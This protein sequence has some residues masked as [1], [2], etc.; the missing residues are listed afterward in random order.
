M[1]LGHPG[2]EDV[3]KFLKALIEKLNIGPTMTHVGLLQFSVDA[4]V[5]YNL[6][7][8]QN[9]SAILKKI[10]EMTYQDGDG[11]RTDLGLSKAFKKV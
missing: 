2:F 10:N 9:K 8:S 11:T 3:K 6:T 4:K 5:E 1:S 7:D